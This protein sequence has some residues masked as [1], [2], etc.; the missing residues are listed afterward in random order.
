M[1]SIKLYQIIAFALSLPIGSAANA[2]VHDGSCE[3]D[4]DCLNAGE[5]CSQFGY[6][7]TGEEYCGVVEDVEVS[8]RPEEELSRV[9]GEPLAHHF[10]I[11]TEHVHV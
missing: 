8:Y 6:C 3:S 11:S 1:R 7:G 2:I 4:W 5:C 10:N 9:R